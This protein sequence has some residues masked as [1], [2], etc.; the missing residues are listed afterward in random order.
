MAASSRSRSGSATGVLSIGARDSRPAARAHPDDAQVAEVD[1]EPAPAAQVLDERRDLVGLDLPAAAASRAEQ[2]AVLHVG[3][4][5]ELLAPVEPVCVAEISDLFEDVERP[6]DRRGD[7]RGIERLA[8]P[9]QLGAGHVA[10]GRG[11]HLDEEPALRSPSKAALVE[12]LADAR[13]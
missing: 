10:I 4:D 3:Q 8:P 12:P 5:M 6:I 1:R 11:Q 9:D 2:V 7:E 13:P